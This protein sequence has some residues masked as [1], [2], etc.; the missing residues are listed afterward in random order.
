MFATLIGP[1]PA[2]DAESGSSAVAELAAL[3]LEPVGDGFG[4]RVADAE[5]GPGSSR[6]GRRPP[7][8]PLRR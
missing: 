7:P 2:A 1:F 5:A 4:A 3:G 6:R 8:R